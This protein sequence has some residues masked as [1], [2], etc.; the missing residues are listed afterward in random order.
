M[1]E[2]EKNAAYKQL[3]RFNQ[4]FMILMAQKEKS[5]QAVCVVKAPILTEPKLSS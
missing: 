3:E 4:D 1:N 5:Y 2:N